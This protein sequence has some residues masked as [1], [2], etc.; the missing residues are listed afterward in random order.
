MS[1]VVR[2]DGDFLT[3]QKLLRDNTLGKVRWVEMAYQKGPPNKAWKAV[4]VHE[5]GHA[6]FNLWEG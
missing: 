4:S 3:V 2:L 5:G 1:T 6:L